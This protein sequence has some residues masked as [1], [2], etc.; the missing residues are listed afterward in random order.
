[1]NLMMTTAREVLRHA[2]YKTGRYDILVWL[3]SRRGWVSVA[4]DKTDLKTRFNTIYDKQ[5]W[6][7][8]GS[9]TAPGSGAGSS[10]VATAVLRDVLPNLLNELHAETLLDVGCGDFFW[11]QHVML[12]QKY[13]GIDVVDAIIEAN[14]S[15]YRR[16]GREF[17][18]RDATV[19]EL[20]EADVVMCRDVLFHLSF[21]D[22]GKL[23]KNI[24]AKKRRYF[25]ATSD[26][27][28]LFNSDIPSGDFR[29]FNLQVRPL[30]FPPPDRIIDDS[31]SS[32]GRIAGVWDGQ[33]LTDIVCQL[34]LPR[35]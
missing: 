24:F 22:I 5:I 31:A 15:L 17:M 30:R 21:N 2:I 20:P 13:V 11:M 16:P 9:R 32:D 23:L 27:Q 18:L 7:Q 14:N 29:L 34:R 10:L 33:R 8:G 1:M 4:F 12:Q 6:Q 28:T 35:G 25:I 26:R 19:D 3:R